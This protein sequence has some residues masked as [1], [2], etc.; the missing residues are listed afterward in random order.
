MS[1]TPLEGWV[2]QVK[3]AL[4]DAALSAASLRLE[5]TESTLI[6]NT[7]SVAQILLELKNLGIEIYIDDFGTG[8]SSLS[9]LH[10]YPIST[11]KIDRSF[12]HHIDS[13][14]DQFEIVRTIIILAKALNMTAIAEGVETE[15]EIEAIRGLGCEYVQGYYFYRPLTCE[16]VTALLEN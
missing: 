11:L 2:E 13:N 16:Q 15:G 14:A 4:T 5:L 7:E 3:Q 10:K 1:D 6:E 9:Y 8:Y 12:I